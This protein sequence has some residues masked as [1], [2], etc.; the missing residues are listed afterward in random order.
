MELRSF[1]GLETERG[2]VVTPP[3]SMRPHEHSTS[4]SVVEPYRRNSGVEVVEGEGA[5]I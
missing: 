3:F 5:P 2:N 1:E 4:Q